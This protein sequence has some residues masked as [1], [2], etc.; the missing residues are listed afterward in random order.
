MVG[1]SCHR[2]KRRL[3]RRNGKYKVTT[4]AVKGNHVSEFTYKLSLSYIFLKKLF[5]SPFFLVWTGTTKTT[6]DEEIIIWSS[7]C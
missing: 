1:R 5:F 3:F 7:K 4:V 2:K 6:L